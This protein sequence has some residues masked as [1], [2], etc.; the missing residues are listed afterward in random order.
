MRSLSYE[1]LSDVL[2]GKEAEEAD[3]KDLKEQLKA[4]KVEVDIL[5]RGGHT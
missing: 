4:L 3:L 2:K 5:R 1:N